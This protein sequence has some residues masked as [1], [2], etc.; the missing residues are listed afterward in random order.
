MR[1]KVLLVLLSFSWAM[2]QAGND[3]LPFLEEGKTWKVTYYVRENTDSYNRTY[4]VQG[5]TIIEGR[6]YKKC[7]EQDTGRYLYAL[8]EKG[9]KVYS[10]V[11][12]DKYGEPN[13]EESLLFDFTVNEGDIIETEVQLLHVTGIDHIK[14][15]RR[16]HIYATSKIYPYEYSGTGVLVEGIGSDRGPLSSYGWGL[17]L[18]TMDECTMEEETLF[19]Y[20]DFTASADATG[21]K[22]QTD[23]FQPSGVIHD[24]Q[25]RR[26]ESQSGKGIYIQNG[27]KVVVK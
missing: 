8:R 26:L 1:K 20:S 5:D 25:G 27:K 24:L 17:S 13:K 4:I 19:N 9:G 16:I 22:Q 23:S 2:A 15:R 11:S 14:N 7:I 10:V 21:L 12:T 6:Q 18:N 3:Y